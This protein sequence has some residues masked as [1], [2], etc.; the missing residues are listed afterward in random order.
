MIRPPMARPVK[1]L[2][3]SAALLALT[4][5]VAACAGYGTES[6]KVAKSQGPLYQGAVLFNQ[7]CSGCHTLVLRRNPRVG[8]ECADRP[9]QQRPELRPAL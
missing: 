9:I 3:V 8:V 7:R 2:L 1:L 4:T 5:T 6:I